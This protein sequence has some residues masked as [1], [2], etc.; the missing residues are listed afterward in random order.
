MSPA[1]GWGTLGTAPD[2]P[3]L[4]LSKPSAPLVEGPRARQVSTYCQG[5]WWGGEAA[6]QPW[7]TGGPLREATGREE[8]GPA[9][10]QPRTSI[11]QS[12]SEPGQV[13]R[14]SAAGT[15]PHSFPAAALPH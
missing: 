8:P 6:E 2:L 10:P 13:P 11:P 4:P 7:D 1:L 15:A 3:L 12:H 14:G 5:H 9:P